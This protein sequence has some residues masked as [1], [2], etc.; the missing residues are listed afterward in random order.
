MKIVV[1]D[2]VFNELINFLLEKN[3]FP[4]NKKTRK[5]LTKVFDYIMEYQSIL[6]VRQFSLMKYSH[7]K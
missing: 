3:T 7:D 4:I 2:F 1:I 5:Q 6:L